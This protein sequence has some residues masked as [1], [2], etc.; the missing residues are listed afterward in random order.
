MTLRLMEPTEGRYHKS[1]GSLQIPSS[2]PVKQ[3]WQKIYGEY[4]NPCILNRKT[5]KIHDNI[6]LKY[7][8]NQ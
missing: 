8:I 5:E 1:T 2:V 3:N 7:N 6:E 4:W